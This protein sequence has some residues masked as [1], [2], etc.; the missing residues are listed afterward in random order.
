MTALP[1]LQTSN[2]R[3]T[4]DVWLALGLVY[5]VWGSTYLA[6]RFAIGTLPPFGMAGGRFLVS[7]SLLFFFLILKGVPIPTLPQW[8]VAGIV[9]FLLLTVANGGVCWVERWVPSGITALLVGTV[10]LWIAFILALGP[11]GS[12]PAW[13]TWAGIFLGSL[14]ILLLV[15]TKPGEGGSEVNLWGALGLVGTSL[16]WAIGSLYARKANMPS[17]PLM[18][19][20]LQMILGGVGQLMISFMLGEFRQFHLSQVSSASWEA[21]VYLTLV[22]SLV[23]F[24]SY[25]WVLKKATPEL[26]STYAF[27]NP[28]IAVFLGWLLAGETLTGSLFLAAGFIVGAVGLVAWGSR[29]GA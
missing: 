26:A 28:I 9:G 2:K 15:L 5:V 10:P 8:K 13:T 11:K 19:T 17:S 27:V 18:G 25:I 7:G 16:V 22:G 3:L 12:K 29:K 1:G 20:A 6:I 23:G 21:W 4:W 14:G 24:T